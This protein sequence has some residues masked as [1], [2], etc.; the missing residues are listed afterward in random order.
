MKKHWILRNLIWAVVVIL[1]LVF[2]AQVVLDAIT[3]HNKEIDVPDFSSLTYEEAAKSARIYDLRVEISDSVY[4]ERIG[5]GCVFSQ[6]P[7]AGSKVKKDRRILL[8]INATMPKTVEMPDLVGYSLRQ[9]MTEIFS[10]G[11]SIGKLSYEPD[12]ATNNV[13]EQRYAGQTIRPGK[14]I[15]AGS[16]IDL[17]L[18]C[19]D[20][21]SAF[22]PQ[23]KG[24]S[25]IVAK[26]NVWDNSLNVG[27][28]IYDETV[29]DYQDT[30]NA[31][32]YRQEPAPS[33]E[34]GCPMGTVID[35]HLTV[36]KVKVS[37]T[38]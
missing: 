17:V 18:G 2:I 34:N 16:L 27:K 12:I 25:L 14:E 11:L 3:R 28:I 22:I 32:V 20:Q 30:L 5:R 15:E 23:L 6:N 37:E 24:Y 8:T 26:E 29:Q 4:N 35:L 31:V 38:E 13:L 9:A 1:V 36:S 21:S 33:G 7:K 10:K 19:D